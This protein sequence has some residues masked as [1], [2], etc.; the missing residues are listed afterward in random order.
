L[1]KC[2]FSGMEVTMSTLEKRDGAWVRAP[3]GEYWITGQALASYNDASDLSDK[4]KLVCLQEIAKLNRDGLIP[5]WSIY[6]TENSE[7]TENAK[8]VLRSIE[9]VK[10]RRL[11]HRHKDS[12]ILNL[13]AEKSER[14]ASPFSKTHIEL[15]DRFFIGI[16][17]E[18]EL[19]QWL[20]E[21]KSKELIAFDD[22]TEALFE[23]CPA[24]ITD[25]IS[26]VTNQDVIQLTVDGWKF[27]HAHNAGKLSRNVFVAMAFT[28]SNGKPVEAT[29]RDAI[30]STLEKND[31]LPII[32]DEVEHNDGIMDKV[33]ASINDSRF[34]IAELTYQK[35]GVYYEAG[36]AK[37]R[38]LPVIHIVSKEQLSLCHFDVKHLNLIVWQNIEDLKTK[39]ENRIKATVL[40]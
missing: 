4:Q 23:E 2:I 14:T 25:F 6:K 18:D 32:V 28:D 9:E 27:I 24:L 36:Y 37:G 20:G 26:N 16:S 5:F 13:L 38:G 7:I 34:V 19:F 33:L 40:I 10:E 17:E 1:A 12:M 30:K 15:A 21:L 8:V 35:S 11:D 22:E 29:A 31:W 3:F 39:L